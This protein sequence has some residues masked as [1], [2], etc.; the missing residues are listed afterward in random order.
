MSDIDEALLEDLDLEAED[1]ED[2]ESAEDDLSEFNPLDPIGLFGGGPFGLLGNRRKG[3]A[4]TAASR[5]YYTP[6]MQPYV[7]QPQF[8]T[9]LNKIRADVSKNAAGIKAL[10]TRV[11]AEQAVNRAQNKA[12]GKQSRINK[13]QS[14]QIAA[15]RRDLQQTQQNSLMLTLLTR[16]KVSQ[17]VT[18]AAQIGGAD[19]PVG[20]RVVYAPEKD[21]TML[22]AIALMGGLGGGSDSSG[23]TLFLALALSG[24]L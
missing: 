3:R 7:T 15:V 12:L 4:K 21:N 18:T 13:R 16:P 11:A 23:Q 2:D 10:D 24:G 20:S 5:P 14:A 9:A 19:V 1:E 8:S 6:G 17:T 22:L